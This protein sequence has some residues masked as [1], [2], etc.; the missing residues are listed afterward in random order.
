MYNIQT[1]LLHIVVIFSLMW[2]IV[3][4]NMQY[5]YKFQFL[6]YLNRSIIV[7]YN[8][9]TEFARLNKNIKIVSTANFQNIMC[10]PHSGVSVFDKTFFI[11]EFRIDGNVCYRQFIMQ[12]SFSSNSW[13]V[14]VGRW[15]IKIFKVCTFSRLKLIFW[16]WWVIRRSHISVDST[17]F[18]I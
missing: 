1:L 12:K 11:C 17:T 3:Y 9:F 10:S 7:R 15:K 6:V 2:Y 14:Y 13:R 4:D 5:K 18:F 8:E 16:N